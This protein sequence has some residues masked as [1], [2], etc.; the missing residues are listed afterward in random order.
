MQ[1]ISGN[2]P[3]DGWPVMIWFH[4]GMFQAGFAAQWDVSAMSIKHKV[5]PIHKNSP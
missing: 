3:G 4:P 5:R 2:P 1:M